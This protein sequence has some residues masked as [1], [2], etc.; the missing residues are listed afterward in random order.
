MEKETVSL[1][2]SIGKFLVRVL[3][4]WV[5]S[6]NRKTMTGKYDWEMDEHRSKALLGS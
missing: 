5:E 4:S 1:I 2:L 6:Q 3:D